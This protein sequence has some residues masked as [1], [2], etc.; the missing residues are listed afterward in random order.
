MKITVD[1]QLKKFYLAF[2]NKSNPKD[3][4]WVPAVGHEIQVGKY[5]FCAIP[6]FDHINVSEVTTG[7]QFL[8]VPMTPKI[9][10]MTSNKEDTLKLFESV[11]EDLIRIINK[12]STAVIDKSLIEQRKDIFNMLGEMPPIEVFDMEGDAE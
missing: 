2:I 1:E 12:H 10:Q 9:Y 11:G 4:H 7:L 5:R 3:C 6:A 8:K